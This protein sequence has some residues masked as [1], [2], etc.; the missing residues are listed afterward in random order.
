M[1]RGNIAKYLSSDVS[2]GCMKGKANALH[3][4]RG[5]GRSRQDGICSTVNVFVGNANDLKIRLRSG[6][7]IMIFVFF[8]FQCVTLMLQNA[9]YFLDA[10]EST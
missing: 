6:N 7:E 10:Q 2:Q 5:G 1:D 8:I 9:F 4:P 3:P